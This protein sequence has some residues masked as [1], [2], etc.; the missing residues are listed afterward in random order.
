MVLAVTPLLLMTVALF[1]WF[2]HGYDVITDHLPMD[3]VSRVARQVGSD[4]HNIEPSSSSRETDTLVVT[5]DIHEQSPNDLDVPRLKRKPSKRGHIRHSSS[6]V[7]ETCLETEDLLSMTNLT[8]ETS[9]YYQMECQP[10]DIV[11]TLDP[12]H[13]EMP[14]NR[15]SGVL[16][17]P[18]ESTI[19]VI[20]EMDEE[21]YIKYL[22]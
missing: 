12:T 18:M 7:T 17:A 8:N 3:I 20:P 11:A 5:K 13:L 4:K 1:W 9:E 6:D 10:E 19:P 15:V 14:M 21:E 22:F 16:D 2:R